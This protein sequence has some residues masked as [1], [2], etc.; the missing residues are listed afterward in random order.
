MSKISIFQEKAETFDK[1]GTH[2]AEVNKAQDS[3]N[4]LRLKYPFNE[5]LIEIEWLDQDKLYKVNPDE[6]GEFFRFME[7]YL[8]PLGY[9]TM[10]SSNVYRNTRLQIKTETCCVSLWMIECG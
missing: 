4:D 3:L 5:N 2:R 9:S 1:V 6:T 7:G 10:T 8:K